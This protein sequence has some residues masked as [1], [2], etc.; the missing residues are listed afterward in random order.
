[1]IIQNKIFSFKI[2]RR[3]KNVFP[4]DAERTV[5]LTPMIDPYIRPA[6]LTTDCLRNDEK[7]WNQCRDSELNLLWP[8]NC[9]I[10]SLTYARMSSFFMFLLRKP[11][12]FCAFEMIR[13]IWWEK[14]RSEDM[15]TPKY[16]VFSTDSR[17][18]P[19]MIG[20][21]DRV[22][23]KTWHLDGLNSISHVFFPSLK[24]IEITLKPL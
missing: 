21:R 23:C 5:P 8:N 13:L 16:R 4:S 9:F 6:S 11:K 12:F 3:V 14:L 1:M 24:N 20:L 22:M 7:Y 19:C 10:S 2:K 15:S 18:C 17:I